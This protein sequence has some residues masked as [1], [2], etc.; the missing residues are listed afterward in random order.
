[1]EKDDVIDYLFN[2]QEDDD[3]LVLDDVLLEQLSDESETAYN[4]INDFIDKKIHPMYRNTLKHLILKYERKM[5][6]SCHRENQLFYRNGV[7]AGVQFVI[8]ALTLK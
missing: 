5:C 3:L 7:A 8:N 1:M 4:V 2:K 6:E